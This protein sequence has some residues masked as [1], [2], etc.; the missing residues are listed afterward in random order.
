MI[1]K[2]FP[3]NKLNSIQLYLHRQIPYNIHTCPLLSRH[4]IKF[5]NWC[6]FSCV[7]FIKSPTDLDLEAYCALY[8]T[9]THLIQGGRWE[10]S[11][12]LLR[13]T[14]CS[15]THTPNDGWNGPTAQLGRNTLVLVTIPLSGLRRG[16]IMWTI[17]L[18]VD[19]EVTLVGSALRSLV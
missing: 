5:W 8:C 4:S 16:G 9:N 13:T 3:W 12:S 11:R 19:L 10:A 2:I 17:S 1:N 14:T 7:L 15:T 18:R 6:S